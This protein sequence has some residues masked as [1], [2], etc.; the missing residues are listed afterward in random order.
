MMFCKSFLRFQTVITDVKDHLKDHSF[1]T[2]EKFSEK[3]TS[4]T[5]WY[6]HV[7]KCQKCKKCL[8]FKS[9]FLS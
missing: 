2:F 1:S 8:Y 6:A 3:L 7:K 4:R 9:Q 5:P